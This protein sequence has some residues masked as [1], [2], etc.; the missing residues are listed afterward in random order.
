MSRCILEYPTLSR[1][2][3]VII[4]SIKSNPQPQSSVDDT[5]TAFRTRFHVHPVK[6]QVSLR[7]TC[8]IAQIDQSSLS[9]LTKTLTQ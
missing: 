5:G 3:R 6:A 8:A 9:I 1:V 2:I 7:G 4:E